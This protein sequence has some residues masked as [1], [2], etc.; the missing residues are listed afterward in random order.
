MNNI[1]KRLSPVIYMQTVNVPA[2]LSPGMPLAAMLLELRN[3]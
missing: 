3:A 1:T 2:L